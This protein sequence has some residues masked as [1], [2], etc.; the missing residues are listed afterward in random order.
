MEALA[1]DGGTL[2][3][4]AGAYWNWKK[5]E[6]LEVAQTKADADTKGLTGPTSA[7]CLVIKSIFG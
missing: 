6:G 1:A 5:S 3:E 4:A 2:N 7:R